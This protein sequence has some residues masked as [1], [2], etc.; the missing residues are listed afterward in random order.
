[1]PRLDVWLVKNGYFSSRQIAKRVIRNGFVTIN[2]KPAK[3][4]SIVRRKDSI[5]V[6]D[7]FLNHPVG[8]DKLK[9]LESFIKTPLVLENFLVLD[10]GSS[11]GG[12]LQYIADRGAAVIGI[13]FSNEFEAELNNIVK[14]YPNISVVIGDAFTI[15]TSIICEE[16]ELDLLLVDVTTDVE[17]TL[18]LIKRFSTLLKN[19]GRLI[20]AIKSQP[21]SSIMN[22]MQM[23]VKDL[24]FIHI[25]EIVLNESLQ[26]FHIIAVR[27]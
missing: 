4:S 19:G 15:E 14:Q 11:A 3:P 26:E 2:G 27:A 1:M 23:Q 13:E 17:G 7:N 10:I 20:A 5:K 12:F 24:G 9:Q 22:E 21:D 18:K 6:L 16:S 25:N 8:Y